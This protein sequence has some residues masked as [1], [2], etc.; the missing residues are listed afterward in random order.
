VEYARWAP[1]YERIARAFRFPEARERAAAAE[2]RQ[3]LPDKAKSDPLGRCRTRIAGREAIVVGLAPEAGAPPFDRLPAA[4]GGRVVLAADGAAAPCLRAGIVPDLVV[5][6]LDGPVA[7]EVTANARGALVVIHAHGDNLPALRGWV[8]EFSGELAGSWSGPPE[9]EL[10]DVGGF[11]DG[12]RA[13]FLAEHCGATSVLLWGFDFRRVD[14]AD[15][16]ERARK[17]AKLRFAADDLVFLA[18]SSR[19][20]LVEWRRD[21]SRRPFQDAASARSTQ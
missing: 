20:P 15:P 3:L 13:A 16:A 10:I 12:E 18:R 14:E 17:L 9:A 1:Q 21:G 5:T 6:D 4:T 19:V 8:P 2:L 11:T 7:S